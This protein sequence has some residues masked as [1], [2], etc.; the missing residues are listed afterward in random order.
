MA[1]RRTKRSDGRFCL[2]ITVENADGTKR[3]VYFLRP[4][5]SKAKAKVAA[6]RER[7]GRGERSGTPP[8][9]CRTGWPSGARH[10]CA[11]AIVPSQPKTCTPGS[12]RGTSSR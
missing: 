2:N 11:P 3:R 1:G 7:V 10:F 4:N 12:R 8:E 5:A 6:A 9:R